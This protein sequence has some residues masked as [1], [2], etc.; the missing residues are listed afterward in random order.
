MDRAPTRD[1]WA[2]LAD[3]A[4]RR[5]NDTLAEGFRTL[6]RP[7]DPHEGDLRLPRPALDALREWLKAS[8][9][10][11]TVA[12][13]RDSYRSHYEQSRAAREADLHASRALSTLL[14][15]LRTAAADIGSGS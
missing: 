11:T 8:E 14:R 13:D 4:Q 9:R 10:V 1:E 5:G 12:L 6:A 3:E 7:Q 15:A 2:E